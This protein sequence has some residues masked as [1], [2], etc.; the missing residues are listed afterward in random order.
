MLRAAL[1]PLSKLTLAPEEVTVSVSLSLMN[2]YCSIQ[3]TKDTSP[4]RTLTRQAVG[5]IGGSPLS[6][7]LSALSAPG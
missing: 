5:N 6:W 2:W 7:L 3:W 4:S 1:P